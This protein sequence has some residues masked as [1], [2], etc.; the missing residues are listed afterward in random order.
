LFGFSFQIDSRVNKVWNISWMEYNFKLCDFKSL[1]VIDITEHMFIIIPIYFVL[2]M[3]LLQILLGFTLCFLGLNSYIVA[4]ESYF[5][6][7]MLYH[8]EYFYV[9]FSMCGDNDSCRRWQ[10]WTNTN[11][12]TMKD[13]W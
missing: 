9:I 13:E 7:E 11:Q 8:L 2:C 1:L 6:F 4:I 3:F 5:D 12:H 10:Q